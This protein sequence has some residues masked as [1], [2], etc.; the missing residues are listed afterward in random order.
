MTFLFCCDS[1]SVFRKGIRTIKWK[2]QCFYVSKRR[3]SSCFYTTDCEFKRRRYITAEFIFPNSHIYFLVLLRMLYFRSEI[4][5]WITSLTYMHT[6]SIFG[7][8]LITL[9]KCKVNP[10]GFWCMIVFTLLTCDF[11]SNLWWCMTE[12]HHDFFLPWCVSMKTLE[13][14]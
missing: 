6:G 9:T 8:F 5:E 10:I 1:L 12:F 4:W 7:R 2:L 13:T 11:F 14:G 3:K